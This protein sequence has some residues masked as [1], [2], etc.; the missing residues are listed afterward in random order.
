MNFDPF[1]SKYHYV[2]PVV[3]FFCALCVLCV[4]LSAQEWKTVKDGVEY[5]GVTREISGLNVN[6]NL[7]RLD[8]TKVRLDVV[9]AMDAAIGTE[10]T[11]S[12]ATRHGAFAA[13]N[14]GFFR[15]DKSQFLG[16]PVGT[17]VLNG[18]A[19]SEGS[20]QR[21]ALII[22]K[23]R[24]KTSVVIHQLESLSDFRIGALNFSNPISISGINRERKSCDVILYGPE[25][26]AATDSDSAGNE[27]IL[28][29]C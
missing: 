15:L 24:R 21:A 2:R 29:R 20:N 11:S 16:D 8:L 26:G 10:K 19:I 4:P 27:L 5:A 23:E 12:I 28:L 6:M 9:H 7:L 3:S 1:T 13:I 14:A 18:R 17:M 25:F 22:Q